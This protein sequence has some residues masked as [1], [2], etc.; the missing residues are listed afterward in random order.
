MFIKLAQ[1]SLK[2]R[3]G[4]VVLTVL[5]MS[6]SIFVLLAVEH[7]RQQSKASFA[8][9]VSGVDL[10]VGA[11]TGSLNLLLYSVFHIGSPSNNI[12]W[13]SYEKIAQIKQVD[14]AVPISLGDSH[15]GY[16]VIGTSTDFFTHFSYGNKHKLKFSEGAAFEKLYDV[17]IGAE[18]AAKLNYKLGDKIVLAHGV[19]KTSFSMHDD[20]PFTVVGILEAT[21][22]PIDQSLYVSL[23]GIEAIHTGWQHGVKQPGS[24]VNGTPTQQ[25][26]PESI[27]AFML[28]L[29]SRLAVF[30]TQREINNYRG[31]ALSAILPGATLAELWQMMSLMENSLRFVASLV[32]VAAILGLSA[33]LMASIRD[34]KHEIH[35]LRI[36]GAPPGFIFLLIELEALIICLL[37]ML[38]ATLTLTASLSLSHSFILSHFGLSISS[39]IFSPNSLYLLLSI[40][41]AALL[42]AAIPALNAYNSAKKP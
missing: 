29:N 23:A 31:E 19:A 38:L 5:A 12:S 8:S 35:L 26:K 7:I 28:G 40:A 39:N 13:A 20:K 6:V 42:L 33:M 30:K 4:S 3:A 25:L 9:T 2:N 15:K 18:L 41:V 22:T 17:V 1:K 36:I 24:A 27:T 37:S 21:G 34:R 32:F 14:W 10:I 16:R 11:R